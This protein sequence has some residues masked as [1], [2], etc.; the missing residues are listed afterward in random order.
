MNYLTFIGSIIKLTSHLVFEFSRKV[1]KSQKM[2]PIKIVRLS[3]FARL[4]KHNL[5]EIIFYRIND[6]KSNTEVLLARIKSFN[7]NQKANVKYTPN[8]NPAVTKDM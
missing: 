2:K 7:R 4:Y 8:H 1:T 3:V 6:Y 5:G